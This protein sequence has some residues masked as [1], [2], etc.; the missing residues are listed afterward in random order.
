MVARYP[1]PLPR[2][3]KEAPPPPVLLLCVWPVLLWA[4]LCPQPTCPPDDS[5]WGGGGVFRFNG[6]MVRGWVQGTGHALSSCP[7][8]RL[9]LGVQPVHGPQLSSLLGLCMPKG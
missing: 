3:S 8:L 9:S 2:T 6:D 7:W 5:H 4:R 1:L